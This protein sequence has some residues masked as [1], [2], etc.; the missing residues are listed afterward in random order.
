MFSPP[1]WNVCTSSWCLF[2]QNSRNQRKNIRNFRQWR[3]QLGWIFVRF[4]KWI[5]IV[6]LT[7][8]LVFAVP[9]S[10]RIKWVQCTVYISK[11]PARFS[12]IGYGSMLEERT[13]KQIPIWLSAIASLVRLEFVCLS[14]LTSDQARP[15]DSLDPDVNW[16]DKLN[17]LRYTCLTPRIYSPSSIIV[18]R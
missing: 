1:D 13:C 7:A 2:G 15:S 4:V 14:A 5:V 10:S 6:I 9:T 3:V 18:A 12:E 17:T 16:S 8:K 11:R